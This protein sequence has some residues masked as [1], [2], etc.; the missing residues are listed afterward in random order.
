MITRFL[1][2]SDRYL[3]FLSA[4]TEGVLRGMAED[5]RGFEVMDGD[6]LSIDDMDSVTLA[7]R[8]HRIWVEQN[9]GVADSVIAEPVPAIRVYAEGKR[10]VVA[11]GRDVRRFNST[12]GA[13]VARY[14]ATLK[15]AGY[16]YSLIDDGSADLV[17]YL[18]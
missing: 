2:C 12:N 11:L 9:E 6:G 4:Q 16:S 17:R 13:G 5:Y 10:Y 1:D 15:W 7:D 3:V 14:V 8:L 18:W